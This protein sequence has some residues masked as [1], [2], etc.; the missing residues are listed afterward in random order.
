MDVIIL[1]A[2]VET[3]GVGDVVQADLTAQPYMDIYM[4]VSVM[5]WW[6]RRQMNTTMETMETMET[7]G[8]IPIIDVWQLRLY[9]HLNI[10]NNITKKNT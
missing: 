5:V 10:C 7:M 1:H 4:D 8:M 9:G 6:L 3:I 2:I